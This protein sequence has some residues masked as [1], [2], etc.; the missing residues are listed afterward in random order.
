MV[1]HVGQLPFVGWVR[2]QAAFESDK[3]YIRI[4]KQSKHEVLFPLLFTQ[5]G[6]QQ[7]GPAT[8][9]LLLSCAEP[10][11]CFY[12]CFCIQLGVWRDGAA[13]PGGLQVQLSAPKQLVPVHRYVCVCFTQNCCKQEGGSEDRMHFL[14]FI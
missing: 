12:C 6:V 10:S 2:V 11:T 3:A 14:A 4:L 9:F 13:V 1:Q 7:A 5:L 8:L